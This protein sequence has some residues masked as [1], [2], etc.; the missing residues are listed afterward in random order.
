M[1]SLPP[2]FV[3]IVA[4]IFGAMV[5][6]FLNV[7]IHRLP[8]GESIVHPRS[9]CPKC[10]DMIPSWLNVPILSWIVLRGKCRACKTPISPRYPLVELMTAML[11]LALAV[12]HGPTLP[13]LHGMILAASLIAI[14]FIDIAIWEI[15]DEISL[16]GI[17]IGVVL[18][19]F[20]YDV[21]WYNGLIGAALGASFLWLVRWAFLKAR[22]VEGMG[23]GDIKLIAM[24]GAFLGPIA[25][26]PTILVASVAGAVIGGVLLLAKKKE[27]AAA[28]DEEPPPPPTTVWYGPIVAVAAMGGSIL[29]WL[30]RLELPL[31]IGISI[32]V[33]LCTAAIVLS[34]LDRPPEGMTEEEEAEEDW[35]PAITAVPYGPFLALGALTY[36]LIGRVFRG[37]MLPY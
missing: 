15:P 24:I 12:Q 27:A 26:L 20:A 33:A 25:L 19:P 35:T 36:L 31:Q 10:G 6:S 18:R 7:V 37:W 28:G 3:Q 23:L 29:L 2:I 30:K 5:G 9:K 32:A 22:G 16:P 11:F 8:A 14:T 1:E 21:P 17:L 34:L 4:F 13:L